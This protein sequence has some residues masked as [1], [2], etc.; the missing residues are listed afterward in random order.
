M[1]KM[2][3]FLRLTFMPRS[4]QEPTEETWWNQIYKPGLWP[5]NLVLFCFCPPSPSS[6]NTLPSLG[7]QS[8]NKLLLSTCQDEALCSQS[9]SKLCIVSPKTISCLNFWTQNSHTFFPVSPHTHSQLTTPPHILLNKWNSL[10]LSSVL[11]SPPSRFCYSCAS[12]F[13][14][15]C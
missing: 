2:T 1:T 9:Q 13:S 11:L 12:T 8:F 4:S 14:P 5:P 3:Q 15:L 7:C 10:E 6:V